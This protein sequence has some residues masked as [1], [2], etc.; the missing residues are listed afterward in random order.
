MTPSNVPTRRL[1]TFIRDHQGLVSLVLMLLTASALLLDY[2]RSDLLG[3][4]LIGLRVI[5]AG[6]ALLTIVYIWIVSHQD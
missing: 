6:I 4:H 3:P 5:Y 1:V 2:L